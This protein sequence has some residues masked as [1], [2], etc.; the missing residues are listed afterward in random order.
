MTETKMTSNSKLI[1]ADFISSLFFLALG[2]YMVLEGLKMPGA[3][4]FIEIG[5]EPGRVPVMIGA[6]LMLLALVLL[7]RS[8][9]QGGWQIW[10]LAD[11]EENERIGIMRT[12]CTAIGCSFYAVGLIGASIAG[13]EVPYYQATAL[14]MFVFIVGFEW[15]QVDVGSARI[16]LIVMA[17]LQA[18]IV[19]SLVVYLFEQKFYVVLP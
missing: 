14:F 1:K 10:K 16:R 19:T 9:M 11:L 12:A 17:L 5:G 7:V 3:G 4:G 8:S 2:A 18:I 6:A 13:W 15:Q